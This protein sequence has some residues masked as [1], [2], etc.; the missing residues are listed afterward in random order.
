LISNPIDS[1]AKQDQINTVINHPTRAG[2]T[3]NVSI[4][5]STRVLETRISTLLALQQLHP[6]IA[7]DPTKV[8]QD[9]HQATTQQ[10][11]CS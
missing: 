9:T 5:S 7:A 10:T 2:K 8:I 6:K 3:F 1:H 4:E 11:C